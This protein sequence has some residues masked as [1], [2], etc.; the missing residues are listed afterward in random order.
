MNKKLVLLV[1]DNELNRK[2][3]LKIVE[4]L[5][6]DVISAASGLEALQI[7]NHK[8]PAI[9]LMDC[10]MPGMDGFETTRMIRQIEKANEFER[11][12][13]IAFT[14]DDK[15]DK[16]EFC[17][18]AGMDD[19]VSKPVDIAKLSRIINNFIG[20]LHEDSNVDI[21]ALI[22]SADNDLIWA[23]E[24]FEMFKDD[25]KA[26]LTKLNTMEIDSFVPEEAARHFHTIKSSAASVGAPRLS[27]YSKKME[28]FVKN[29][30]LTNLFDNMIEFNSEFEK[31]CSVI[32][33]QINR[34]I[35]EKS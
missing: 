22:L 15:D 24:L 6:F 34:K 1:D 8:K 23:K 30:E 3:T 21:E 35:N 25:T 10:K 14:A 33:Q 17:R 13:V 29:G 20:R 28:S 32:E 7:Y 2:V 27:D 5:G 11:V 12:P 18:S 4:S 16:W 31:I 9:I 19:F 26:R